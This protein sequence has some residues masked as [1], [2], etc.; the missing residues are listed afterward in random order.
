M[1]RERLS[2]NVWCRCQWC[3]RSFQ[4]WRPARYCCDAHKRA[5]ERWKG[6]KKV[7]ASRGGPKPVKGT[8]PA[9]QK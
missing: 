1:A 6:T 8:P 2:D 9:D 5:A 7:W 4:N 3:D